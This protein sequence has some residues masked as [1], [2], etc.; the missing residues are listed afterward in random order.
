M[1]SQLLLVIKQGLERTEI[2]V[3]ELKQLQETIHFE[4]CFQQKDDTKLAHLESEQMHDEANLLKK[5]NEN[6]LKFRLRENVQELCYIRDKILSD[7]KCTIENARKVMG[8]IMNNLMVWKKEQQLSGNGFQMTQS[9]DPI[10]KWCED[11]VGIVLTSRQHIQ[12]IEALK[13][14]LKDNFYSEVGTMQLKNEV[15]ELLTKLVTETFIVQKQPSQVMRTNTKSEASVALLAGASLRIH[16]VSPRVTVSII[17]ETEAKDLQRNP[18]KT[19][20]SLAGEIINSQSVMKLDKVTGCVKA[21][22]PNLKIKNIR[23]SEKSK[24]KVDSVVEEKFFLLFNT[25]IHVIGATYNV[26]TLTLPLAVV[27]HGC[28]QGQLALATVTWD[29]A[30]TDITKRPLQI[31]EEVTWVRVAE[32]LDMKWRSHCRTSRGLSEDN[33]HFLGCKLFQ[34]SNLTREEMYSLPVT[35]C[36]LFRD[37]LPN[38]NF[39]FWEWFYNLMK[40]T[41]KYTH[42]SWCAGYIL[43]FAEKSNVERILLQSDPGTCLLRFSDSVLGGVT[44]AYAA[45][46]MLTGQ[47]SLTLLEPFDSKTLSQRSLGHCLMDLH[48][49]GILLFVYQEPICIPLLTA[50]KMYASSIRSAKT[51]YTKSGL[52]FVVGKNIH[53]D[54]CLSI[55][56]T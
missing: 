42:D 27:V 51:G 41:E 9:L 19:P 4:I 38:R 55:F 1:T 44:L 53:P 37:N 45:V 18:T 49:R 20:K 43:G 36:K 39:S 3:D 14:T 25:D 10:Q 50:F 13:Q 46:D 30:F 7:V 34:N 23:R 33:I 24:R 26:W 6:H 2:H 35:R 22:F 56:C 31:P 47:K 16:E 28:H 52:Q 15:E 5:S 17:S 21:N 32:M 29:N 11:L 40:I 48:I 12:K 8:D 54:A